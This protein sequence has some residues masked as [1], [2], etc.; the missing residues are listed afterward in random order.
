[1]PP[2]PPIA[3][4]WNRFATTSPGRMRPASIS[5]NT[6]RGLPLHLERRLERLGH[7]DLVL[8]AHP[9]GLEV[10]ELLAL[11]H[12]VPLLGPQDEHHLRPRVGGER[13]FGADRH[14]ARR[15]RRLAGPR[16]EDVVVADAVLDEAAL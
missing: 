10:L 11:D 3:S 13:V 12:L 16:I 14:R 7:D 6:G 15:A 5:S 4:I 2:V 1:M 8:V 9:E